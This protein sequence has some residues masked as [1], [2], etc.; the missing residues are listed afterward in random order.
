MSIRIEHI[1][2]GQRRRDSR[3]EFDVVRQVGGAWLIRRD[4]NEVQKY[5]S[6]VGGQPGL[7]WLSSDPDGTGSDRK[8]VSARDAGFH[9]S[10]F[11]TLIQLRDTELLVDVLPPGEPS[12]RDRIEALAKALLPAVVIDQALACHAFAV[13][14]H[15]FSRPPNETDDAKAEQA[16]ALAEAFERAVTKRRSRT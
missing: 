12:E 4:G 13:D 9:G 2:P 7:F 10:P 1:R 15:S 6:E 3:G 8:L 14:P 16:F 11:M 5:V